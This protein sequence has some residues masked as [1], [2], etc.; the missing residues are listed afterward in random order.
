MSAIVLD[1]HLKSALSAVRSLGKAGISLSV[2][3]ERGTAMALH[4]RYATSP[5]TYPSPL[6]DRAAFVDAVKREAM[7]RGGKPLI[8]AMSDATYLALYEARAEFEAVAT[9]AYPADES[10]ALAFNKAAT[11][12]LAKVSGVPTIPTYESN[13]EGGVAEIARKLQYPAVVKPRRSVTW[14]GAGGSFG[15]ASFAMDEDDLKRLVR[16]ATER[17]GEPPLVQEMVYGEEYGVEMLARSGVPYARVT[18]HRIRSLSPKGGA[19]VVKETLR[20][21]ELRSTLERYAAI[22]VEKLAWN[23]PIMVEFK[24]DHDSRTPYLME[25]NGRFWGSLPLSVAARV[26]MPLLWYRAV[27]D[28]AIP[29]DVVTGREDVVTGHFLGD[30][31]HLVRVLFARDPMRPYL[32]PSRAQALRNFMLLPSGVRAD[33]W[34]VLDPKP[35]LMEFVDV[36]ASFLKK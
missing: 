21:G 31:V 6:M 33:V 29:E 26:D 12:S 20:S 15:T 24:V 11:Y 36:I 34:S 35:S 30:V 23:G 9:L 3:A 22:L 2:G 17:F 16:T 25:V 8:F 18:H 32:Y 7:H 5:F 13:T 27:M 10:V 4:S 28:G 19:S 1:G 14:R